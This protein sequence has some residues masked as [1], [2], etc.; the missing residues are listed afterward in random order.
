VLKRDSNIRAQLKRG[1]IPQE[2]AQVKGKLEVATGITPTYQR[3]DD[4]YHCIGMGGGGYGDPL[5]REI[6]LVERDV[7]NGL[8]T[9]EWAEKM[10]GVVGRGA[11]WQADRDATRRRRDDLYQ[12]RKRNVSGGK[13]SKRPAESGAQARRLAKERASAK[14]KRS[15][16]R[17]K[18]NGVRNARKGAERTTK[19]SRQ[20]QSQARV[21]RA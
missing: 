21:T 10:Y 8:V 2:L 17:G 16:A 20:S 9:P 7:V 1:Q 3:K 14:N 4:V 19:R 11:P 13:S 18:K 6:D 15:A 5:A 12:E